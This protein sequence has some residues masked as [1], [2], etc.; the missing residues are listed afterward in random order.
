MNNLLD[1]KKTA[2]LLLTE[3]KQQIEQQLPTAGRPPKLAAILIGENPASQTYVRNKITACQKTG[4]E[5]ALYK[6]AATIST[7]ELLRLIQQLNTDAT[8]D[9]ILVQLPLPA[10]IPEQ[11][12][13]EAISPSKD[14]DGFHPVNNGKMLQNLPGFKPATPAGIIA[15]LE[16]N[17]I[18]ISGKRCVVVG[19]SKIVGLPIA[20]LLSQNNP[21][22]NATVTLCHTR[23][24][25]LQH[26]TRDA[27]I[28]IVA[29]GKPKF[30][31]TDFLTAGVVVID[32]GIHQVP[33]PKNPGKS[34]L[35][36][37]VDFESVAGICSFITPVPGGV[38]P[39]TIA[40]L[41]QNTVAAW[42]IHKN[43][44]IER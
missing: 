25:D 35:V 30:I 24:A 20:I 33:D 7:A 31:T 41:L 29:A 9:G 2:Q 17:Q 12:V 11:L 10:H 28:I 34:T 23:T 42:C 8:I 26:H 5:S 15:L 16:R 39:M 21:I 19:R 22:G 1:G 40:A 3:L 27:E 43:I 36:G 37:D 13:I 32:V 44:E 14:V 38:G 18:S 4:I 6:L